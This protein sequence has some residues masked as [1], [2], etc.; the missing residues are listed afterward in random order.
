[1]QRIRPSHSTNTR[2]GLISA[3]S[4]SVLLLC[5]SLLLAG[6]LSEPKQTQDEGASE[7]AN[8]PGYGTS[9]GQVIAPLTFTS[10]DDEP[11]SLADVFQVAENRI[12]LLTTS[13]GWCT[14]CIEEQPKLQA[15]YDEYGSRGLEIMV[16]LFE[17]ADSSPADARLAKSWKERYELDFRVVADPEFVMQPYYPNG[18]A[19]VTTIVVMIDVDTMTILDTMVGFQEA[20][21]RAIITNKIGE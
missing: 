20:S 18:D 11:T 8:Y 9:A 13:A 19:S 2:R 1:M 4:S 21:V 10:G 12:L 3:R 5:R 7:R 14:A 15:L 6:C 16:V 17:K